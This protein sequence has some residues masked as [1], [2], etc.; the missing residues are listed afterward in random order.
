MANHL[1]TEKLISRIQLADGIYTIHD[2]S[3]IHSLEDLRLE[4]NLLIF[5]GILDNISDLPTKNNKAGDVYL[6]REDDG[7]YI[8][9]G[10]AWQLMDAHIVADH[11]HEVTIPTK[12]ETVTASKVVSEGSVTLGSDV[13]FEEGSHTADTFTQGDDVFNFNAGEYVAPTLEHDYEAPSLTTTEDSFTANEPTKLD[14]SKF[15]AGSFEQGTDTFTKGSGSFTQGVDEFNAGS[16]EIDYTAPT[17]THTPGTFEQGEDVF[18]PDVPTKLDLSKFNAGSCSISDGDVKF[19][20]L[21]YTAPS[22]TKG[23]HTTIDTSKFT[24]P[25]ASLTDGSAKLED[26]ENPTWEAKVEDGVLSFNFTEGKHGVVNYVK[27]E[28]SFTAGGFESGFYTPGTDAQFDAGSASLTGGSYTKQ[29]LTCVAPSFDTGFYTEGTAARFVQGTDT[30]TPGN[31]SITEGAVEF[32]YVAPTFKQG[33]DTHTHTA[34]TFVQ[35]SD[36]YVA[37]KFNAGFYTEGT[38]ARFT[39]GTVN[40]SAGHSNITFNEGSYKA[41]TA[42]FTQGKDVFTAGTYTPC[43]VTGGKATVVTL[44]TFADVNNIWAGEKNITVSTG[45]AI[46]AE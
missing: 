13:V 5:K 34:S 35:G 4:S 32:D 46:E 24:V 14:L 2:E 11:T 38:A 21:S 8:W 7:E 10:S 29:T 26:F 17:L 19:P 37:P 41:P 44:P 9:D 39:A 18:T 43:K 33:V 25:S 28:L 27:P 3:A 42:T 31:A 23:T 15:A 6:V 36:T 12:N 1:D 20:T 40:F 45:D 30:W 22:Y 16:L